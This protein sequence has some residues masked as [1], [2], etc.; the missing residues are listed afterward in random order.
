MAN[1][2]NSKEIIHILK[3]VETEH[4]PQ[5]VGDYDSI[6]VPKSYG[7]LQ[8]QQIAIDDVNRKYGTSYTH[9]DAFDIECAEEIFELYIQMWTTHLEKKQGRQ[10][11]EEDIVRIWNGGP[12]GWRRNST[13]KYL[14]KYRE[15]KKK[16]KFKTISMGRGKSSS[17]INQSHI[18][19]MLKKVKKGTLTKQEAAGDLNKRFMRLKNDNI[20]MYDDLYPVYINLFKLT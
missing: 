18:E 9:Q 4:N 16:H 2:S 5:A 7:I 1:A 14:K 11:T 15:Y 10:A 19:S 8:I 13:L 3:Y 6:G 12:Q 17:E 20:G